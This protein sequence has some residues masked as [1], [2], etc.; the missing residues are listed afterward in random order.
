ML[1]TLED[2]EWD[3]ISNKNSYYCIKVPF[4]SSVY[5]LTN[6]FSDKDYAYI[7]T[8]SKI[9]L[10]TE[11]HQV[12]TMQ[13]FQTALND[14]DIKAIELYYTSPEVSKAFTFNLDLQKLRSG[15]S[16]VVSNSHVKAKKKFR[17]N[18][19]YIGLKSY[20]HCIRILT[21]FNYLAREGT[22]N[23]TSFKNELE[24]VYLDIMKRE[25]NNPETLFKELE[26]DY[27]MMLKNLQHCFRLYC[28]KV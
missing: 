1:K 5:G 10:D 22:F 16:K 6:K 21:M 18:E 11:E 27:K 25:S 8:N 9:D 24:Y 7:V 12:Y 17:D 23:P 14:H 28:P 2:I 4:G 15:V 3:K 19:I 26:Q 20:Y 13:E